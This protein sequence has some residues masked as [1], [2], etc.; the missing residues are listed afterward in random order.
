MIGKVLIVMFV[1]IAQISAH[2]IM[3]QPQ[4]RAGT[5]TGTGAKI[6][7]GLQSEI[8]GSNP[9]PPAGT[10]TATYQAGSNITVTW[11][12]TIVHASAPGVRVAIIYKAGDLF[13][14]NILANGVDAGNQGCHSISVQLPAGKTCNNC[15]LQWSWT[16]TADGGF[17]IGCS[18]IVVQSGPVTTNNTY[19][20][21]AQVCGGAA[22]TSSP[23]SS[24]S[25]KG[26]GSNVPTSVA[27]GVA[28]GFVLA[29][30][31]LFTLF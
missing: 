16:S 26:T 6:S 10:V 8:C 1:L 27:S 3:V 18:D 31:F 13:A 28:V 14:D 21:T 30:P 9:N 15:T 5:N 22:P 24:S 7:G 17:Y 2:A 20:Y 4:P 23:T 11:D 25:S 19:P 12:T 29:L